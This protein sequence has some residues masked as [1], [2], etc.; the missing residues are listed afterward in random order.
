MSSDS[1]GQDPVVFKLKDLVS[2]YEQRLLQLGA[3]S[4][5]I[6]STRL[7]EKLLS[8]I[9]ELEEHKKGRD[10]LL[11]LSNDA[12]SDLAAA[13]RHKDDEAIYLAK[14]AKHDTKRL[15]QP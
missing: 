7:K 10:V 9:I 1:N 4:P 14:A 3:K 5:A 12:D 13:N 11:W 15:A 8:S 2:L 6:H